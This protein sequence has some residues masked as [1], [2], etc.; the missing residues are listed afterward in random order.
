[1]TTGTSH[2]IP[3]GVPA[4]GK[5]IVYDRTTRDYALYLDG[6]LVGYAC[7]VRAARLTLEALLSERQCYTAPA[8][9]PLPLPPLAL[10]A[11]A[12]EDLAAAAAE[13]EIY[14]EARARLL[15]GVLVAASGSDRLIDGVRVQGR[16]D[17][18]RWPWRCECGLPRCWHG[19]LLNGI[20]A[21][22]ERL[23]AEEGALPFVA[24]G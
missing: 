6:D 17:G 8:P 1:M 4:A 23:A 12:L 11:V 18:Q 10:I 15:A 21:A 3:A 24:A 13:P 2:S 16:P 14:R 20:V 22:W 19:A 7:N 9:D 5:Q